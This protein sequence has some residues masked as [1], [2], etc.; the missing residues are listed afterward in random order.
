MTDICLH[1]CNQGF[2][3]R[4]LV[5]FLT[6]NAPRVPNGIFARSAASLQ[7]ELS[8][9]RMLTMLLPETVHLLQLWVFLNAVS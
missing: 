9:F 1:L 4:D 7:L 5:L 3:L 6:V 2:F 8:V